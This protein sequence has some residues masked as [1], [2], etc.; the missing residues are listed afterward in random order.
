MNEYILN[1]IKRDGRKEPFE[2][3]KIT[4][5]IIKAITK[6]NKIEQLDSVY[7]IT[8]SIVDYI[9]FNFNDTVDIHIIE[10]IVENE[11][12][13]FDKDVAR[14]YTSYRGARDA[15][16]MRSSKLIAKI[17]GLLDYSDPDIIAENA[18]KA[19]D[20]LYVQRDLLAGT[21]AKEITKDLNLIP[22]R[23]QKYRDL[24]YIHWHDEDYSPLFQMYNC[25]LIDYR[26]MLEKGFIIGN[27]LIESPKSF[28]VACTLVSQI[29]QGVACSQYGGQT[30]NR[31]DEGLEPYVLKSYV[32]IVNELIEN[33]LT[34]YGINNFYKFDYNTAMCIDNINFC[35]NG[36]V[37]FDDIEC[38]LSEE[39]KHAI[40]KTIID[41]AMKKIEKEVYD[42]IQCLEYQVN[43]LFTTNGQTPFV[44]FSFG[45]GTSKESRM[46]QKSILE[47]RIQGIGKYRVT[48]VFPKLLFILCKG[49]NYFKEDPNYDIKKLAMKCASQR[50]YPDVLCYDNVCKIA[51]GTVVYK[52]KDHKIVDIEKST[53]LI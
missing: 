21:V 46:I 7:E 42:G 43:T 35:I 40:N 27:A 36:D 26:T 15:S 45:L 28:G 23:V 50:M 20:K 25:M 14:E 32:K 10:Q 1:V 16:R 17:N 19:A 38:E 51:S 4:N 8:D 48:P 37:I 9:L 49:I 12:M 5:A 53:G 29:I 44:S 47:V 11:L 30:I 22:A 31:I 41:K 13:E 39:T 52:D 24:N 2:P 3:N 6:L 33:Y 18:N 34:L